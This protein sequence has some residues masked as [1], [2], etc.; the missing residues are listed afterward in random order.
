MKILKWI[1]FVIFSVASVLSLVVVYFMYNNL[2]FIDYPY[3]IS[4]L[5]F[6]IFALITYNY[7]VK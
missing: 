2:S 7:K 4:G 3:V 1:L 5:I 6:L